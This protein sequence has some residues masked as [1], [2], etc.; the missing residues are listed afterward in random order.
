METFLYICLAL[1]VFI[2]L[3]TLVLPKTYI[4]KRSVTIKKPIEEVFDYL[5]MIKN[6]DLWSPWKQKDP[7]MK[8]D[9]VGEDGAIGFIAKWEGNKE[10]GQGEQELVG[11]VEN[12]SIQT[13]L[14]FFKPWKSESEG[15][16][17]LN[18]TEDG[19]TT[20]EWGFTGVNNPPMNILMLFMNF[21]KAVGNDFEEGLE[22]LKSI[23]EQN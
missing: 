17:Y 23:L 22:K 6:Q 15:F 8:Q 20:V 1:I 5:K 9:Y 19:K 4:V 14:R 12:E 21:E 16:F 13:K 3:L 2:G 18:S 10:V 11:L 7:N